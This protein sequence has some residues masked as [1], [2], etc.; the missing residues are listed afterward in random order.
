MKASDLVCAVDIGA[1][2]A[3]NSYDICAADS[4]ISTAYAIA[5]KSA[6]ANGLAD[7]VVDLLIN[8]SVVVRAHTH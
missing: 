7:G 3:T 4:K 8:C 6:L 1:Y 5:R 2:G